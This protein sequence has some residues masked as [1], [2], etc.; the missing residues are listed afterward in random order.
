MK[1]QQIKLT[2]LRESLPSLKTVFRLL[3]LG[4]L[5]MP[6]RNRFF[7][8]MT[9]SEQIDFEMTVSSCFTL[10]QIIPLFTNSIRPPSCPYLSL[11]TLILQFSIAKCADEKLSSSLASLSLVS[12]K[13]K[14]SSCRSRNKTRESR[15]FFLGY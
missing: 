12:L 6:L 14:N 5:Q 15:I 7:L 4:G 9:I 3:K 13:T 10:L 11:L 2:L 1:F 8:E